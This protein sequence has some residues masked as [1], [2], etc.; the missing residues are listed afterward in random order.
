MKLFIITLLLAAS[1][2]SQTQPE[3]QYEA[4]TLKCADSLTKTLTGITKMKRD[5][6]KGASNWEEDLKDVKSLLGDIKED[7][8]NCTD[9]NRQD[10]INWVYHHLPAHVQTCMFDAY[11]MTIQLKQTIGEFKE[12]EIAL[13]LEDLVKTAGIVKIV[14]QDCREIH[15]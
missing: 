14:V 11:Q 13:G 5:I 10:F 3:P 6:K 8:A 9:M 4:K 1:V 15:F 2:L 7:I 12:K